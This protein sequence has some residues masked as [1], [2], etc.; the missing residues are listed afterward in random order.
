MK[1]IEVNL[2]DDVFEK[3]ES[4]ASNDHPSVNAFVLRK[5]EEFAR[6][7]DDFMELER[8]AQWGDRDRF[9]AAMARVPNVPPTP[10]DEL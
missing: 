7:L 3:L 4:L 9:Q 10:G 1:A 6:A 8:R 2:P 5:L